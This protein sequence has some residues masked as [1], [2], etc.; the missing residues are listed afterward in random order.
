MEFTRIFF[1]IFESSGD[2]TIMEKDFIADFMQQFTSYSNLDEVAV[3]MLLRLKL[4][5]GGSD[6]AS[7]MLKF[8]KLLKNRV[9]D[10]YI[11]YACDNHQTE[12]A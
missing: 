6:R 1:S 3:N 9:G 12:T 4:R 11:H 10:N 8:G 2:S 7:K 5:S